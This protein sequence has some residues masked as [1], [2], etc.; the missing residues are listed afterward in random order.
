MPG[1]HG[2]HFIVKSLVTWARLTVLALATLG[3]TAHALATM[4]KTIVKSL[5]PWA[6]LTVLALDTLGNTVHAL[7]TMGNTFCAILSHFAQDLLYLPWPPWET[8]HLP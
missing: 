2:Q 5:V 1:N 6:R 3:N 8:L 4:G 7:A